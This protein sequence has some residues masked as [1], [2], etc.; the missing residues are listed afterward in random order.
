MIKIPDNLKGHVY[1]NEVEKGIDFE[2][3]SLLAR[4]AAIAGSILVKAGAD[5]KSI[6]STHVRGAHLIASARIGDI[7]D[8]NLETE[9]KNLYVAD[10]SVLPKAPGLPPVYTI[11]ALS[12]RLGQFL[13]E[14]L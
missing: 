10:G 8:S 4:G 5:I 3:A 1:L 6:S 7:V 13:R 9:I 2:D 12:R 11:L 14:N